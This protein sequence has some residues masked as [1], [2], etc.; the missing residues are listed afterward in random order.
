MV[1]ACQQHLAAA[2]ASLIRT[3]ACTVSSSAFELRV[4]VLMT[5]YADVTLQLH[6][7]TVVTASAVLLPGAL[8]L[9]RL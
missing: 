7:N 4:S 1:L 8:L 9:L 2:Y 5:A 3:A 6:S